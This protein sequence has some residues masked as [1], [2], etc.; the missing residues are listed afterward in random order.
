MTKEQAVRLMRAYGEF[1]AKFKTA[2]FVHMRGMP[3]RVTPE[4]SIG[5][6]MRW[7][8]FMQGALWAFEWFTLEDLKEHSRQAAQSEEGTE[9]ELVRNSGEPLA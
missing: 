4:F 2:R 9:L 8:G 5:K 3:E 1:A 7:L 6:T